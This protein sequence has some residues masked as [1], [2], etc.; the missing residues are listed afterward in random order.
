MGQ[1]KYN[2][3]G[4]SNTYGHIQPQA[5]EVEKAVLGAQMI[6][7]DA[8]SLISGIVRSTTYYDQRHQMIQEAIDWLL[9]NGNPIDVLTV[10]ERLSRMGK[11]EEVGGPGYIVITSSIFCKYCVSFWHPCKQ[12]PGQA[13]Y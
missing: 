4:N 7:R 12:K 9:D 8:P 1:N 6:D 5:I 11:L 3:N 10:T 13:T 2:K